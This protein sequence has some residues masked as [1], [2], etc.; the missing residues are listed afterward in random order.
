[1]EQENEWK[2]G[3]TLVDLKANGSSVPV[4][5][6]NVEEYVQVRLE[7]DEPL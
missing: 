2:D 4:T 6:N 3:F 5:A 7:D 1:M